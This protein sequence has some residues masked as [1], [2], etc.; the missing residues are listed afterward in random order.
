MMISSTGEGT[1]AKVIELGLFLLYTDSTLW[2][3]IIRGAYV[4]VEECRTFSETAR[5][6]W[7]FL[8]A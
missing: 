1:S 2:G 7:R 6:C 4:E 3:D 5:G 8:C